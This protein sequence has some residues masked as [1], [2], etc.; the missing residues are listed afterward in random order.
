MTIIRNK[1]RILGATFLLVTPLFASAVSGLAHEGEDHGATPAASPGVGSV[2]AELSHPSHIHRGTCN[3]LD[4]EPLREL[5]RVLFPPVP[6]GAP[7][8]D[9]AIP[10]MTSTTTLNLTLS[11]L[12]AD[13]HAVDVHVD[14]EEAGPSWPVERS[15]ELRAE[16]ISPSAS[17]S[18]TAVLMPASPSFKTMV[19]ERLPSR[20]FSPMDLGSPMNMAAR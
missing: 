18:R 15:A 3:R 6:S 2:P 16:A 17:R 9:G 7:D 8:I 12:L 14:G 20:S 11:D 19:T 5:A 10:V 1:L 4:P 13:E